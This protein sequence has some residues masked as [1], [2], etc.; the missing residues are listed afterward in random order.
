MCKYGGRLPRLWF[1]TVGKYTLIMSIR[2]AAIQLGL[3]MCVYILYQL[4]HLTRIISLVNSCVYDAQML[5]DVQLFCKSSS[6]TNHHR[7]GDLVERELSSSLKHKP[8]QKLSGPGTP[9]EA[10]NG[11]MWPVTASPRR[12]VTP[13]IVSMR[14]VTQACKHGL[15]I[16]Q[17]LGPPAWTQTADS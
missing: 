4:I 10:Y 16:I 7:H 11:P 2:P 14:M 5:M 8:T 15:I 17:D 9:C 6:R 13:R 12:D 1:A 3:S